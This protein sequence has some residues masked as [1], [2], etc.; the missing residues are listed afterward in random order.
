MDQPPLEQQ[1]LYRHLRDHRYESLAQAIESNDQEGSFDPAVPVMPGTL[2][3]MSAYIVLPHIIHKQ[4]KSESLV[5]L[6]VEHTVSGK[7]CLKL[8]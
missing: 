3:F 5:Y 1:V 6:F 7:G 2:P 8:V 4:K